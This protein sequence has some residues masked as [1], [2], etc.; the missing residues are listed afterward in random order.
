MHSKMKADWA[1]FTKFYAFDE[2]KYPLEQF[3]IDM[4][5]FKEQYEVGALFWTWVQA[6]VL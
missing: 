1:S 5:T 3:F 6:A 4:K 2:K